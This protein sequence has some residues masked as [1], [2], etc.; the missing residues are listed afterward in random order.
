VNALEGCV[1]I[2]TN[3]IL[4]FKNNVLVYKKEVNYEPTAIGAPMTPG[5]NVIAV[6]NQVKLI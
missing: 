3:Q 2:T 5:N 6:G 1:V 4:L